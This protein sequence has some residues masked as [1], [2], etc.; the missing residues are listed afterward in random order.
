MV[1]AKVEFNRSKIGLTLTHL[2]LKTVTP[3]VIYTFRATTG[4]ELS[5]V[6]VVPDSA[7][8]S[9]NR[10]RRAFLIQVVTGSHLSLSTS[11]CFSPPH[12]KIDGAVEP[13]EAAPH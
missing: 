3:T 2:S 5:S 11:G 9:R 6:L 7:K 10:I 1:E 12:G 13:C 8:R 4:H